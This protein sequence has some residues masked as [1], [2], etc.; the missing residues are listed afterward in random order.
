MGIE[1]YSIISFSLVITGLTAT[2]SR[3][4]AIKSNTQLDRERTLSTFEIFYIAIAFIVILLIFTF[5]TQIAN[6]WLNLDLI[7]PSKV[8]YYL[9]L[10]GIGIAFQLLGDF[11]MGGLMGLE[12]QVKSNLYQVGWGICRNALVVIP[13]MYNPSLEL[14]FIWQTTTTIIYA[15]LLRQFLIKKRL[16]N[17]LGG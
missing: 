2:L 1:G 7:N 5:S 8:S 15:F 4:F 10:I 3:E 9:R 6:N 12:Q 14:F 16:Y 13:L 17:V 11:Y